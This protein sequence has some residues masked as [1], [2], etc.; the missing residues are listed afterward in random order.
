MSGT[1]K[2]NT[3]RAGRFPRRIVLLAD[4]EDSDVRQVLAEYRDEAVSGARL[5]ED[6]RRHADDHPGACVAAEWLGP[7][8]W[9][10]FL[11]CRK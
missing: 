11:W 4:G 1:G 8:G 3:E 9:V 2:G 6:L 5:H 10:R 7:L